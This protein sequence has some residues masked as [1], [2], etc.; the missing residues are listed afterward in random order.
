MTLQW[1]VYFLYHHVGRSYLYVTRLAIIS[2]KTFRRL[3][4]INHSRLTIENIN[5]I[6][7]KPI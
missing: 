3:F 5:N 7:K 4:E 6:I 2:F 1:K